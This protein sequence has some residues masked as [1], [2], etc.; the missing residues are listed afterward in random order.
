MWRQNPNPT[1]RLIDLVIRKL[2]ENPPKR[3]LDLGAGDEC[4]IA[5][6]MRGAFPDAEIYASDIVTYPESESELTSGI[7]RLKSD[8]F[9]SHEFRGH[10][11][12]LI[13]CDPNYL[14]Q[15]EWEVAG[16]PEPK[17]AFT[18][19]GDGFSMIQG[20][21]DAIPKHLSPGGMVAIECSTAQ[22]KRLVG[23]HIVDGIFAVYYNR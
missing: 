9:V 4:W 6:Q 16:G 14:T 12:D 18:D 11:F 7:I 3:I 17:V 21:I 5:K 10:Q 19:G 20:I 2:I 8:L 1:N 15:K 22:A 13:I 23:W